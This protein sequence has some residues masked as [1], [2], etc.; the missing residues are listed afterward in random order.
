M[1]KTAIGSVRVWR[2][3][4]ITE[5]RKLFHENTNDRIAVATTARAHERQRHAPEHAEV[6]AAVDQ[7]GVLEIRRHVLEEA[8]HHPDDDRQAHD[9]VRQDERRVR[10]HQLQVPEEDVPGDE[11]R[12][13][14]G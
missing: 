1:L 2:P 3:A 5:N 11:V 4:R 9:Q 14:R 6:G 12:D 10:V 13:A 8:D 7:G